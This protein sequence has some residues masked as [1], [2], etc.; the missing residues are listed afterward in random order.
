MVL[1]VANCQALAAQQ[2][3]VAA[4][5]FTSL[6]AAHDTLRFLSEVHETCALQDAQRRRPRCWPDLGHSETI[7]I[8]TMPIERRVKEDTRRDRTAAARQSNDLCSVTTTVLRNGCARRL[9]PRQQHPTGMSKSHSFVQAQDA[10]PT[11]TFSRHRLT[12][13]SPTACPELRGTQGAHRVAMAGAGRARRASADYRSL[14]ERSPHWRTPPLPS[15]LLSS[16]LPHADA[17]TTDAA[18][19]VGSRHPVP[20]LGC[21]NRCNHLPSRH[22]STPCL[23]TSQLS[24]TSPSHILSSWTTPF[25]PLVSEN[26]A[27]PLGV[28]FFTM[29]PPT[30]RD[31]SRRNPL[32]PSAA[33]LRG[34]LAT[35]RARRNRWTQN[36]FALFTEAAGLNCS[37]TPTLQRLDA[38]AADFDERI[39][40]LCAMRADGEHLCF[41][42]LRRVTPVLSKLMWRGGCVHRICL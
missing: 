1:L 7:A 6:G 18:A 4:L 3:H 30:R 34:T 19:G 36:R 9:T 29:P 20:K 8:W 42:F 11:T 33:A 16:S 35:S 28:P 31:P 17:I 24:R 5:I 12:E 23:L 37:L 10:A 39:Q 15:S 38:L 27:R 26:D 22:T 40:Q 41:K 14:A 13:L 25:W 2:R 32:P 21:K